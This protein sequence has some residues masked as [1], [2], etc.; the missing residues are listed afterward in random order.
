MEWLRELH[1]AVQSAAQF[2]AVRPK[3]AAFAREDA[4]GLPVTW[5]RMHAAER[6]DGDAAREAVGLALDAEVDMGDFAGLMFREFLLDLRLAE[7]P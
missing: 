1:A 6:F 3:L 5:V 7:A 4:L 2:P